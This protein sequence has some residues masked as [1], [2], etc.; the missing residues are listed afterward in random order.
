MTYTRLTSG[1]RIRQLDGVNP[2]VAVLNL[3]HLVAR[4]MN[5]VNTMGSGINCDIIS[6]MNHSNLAPFSYF[7]NRYATTNLWLA[8]GYPLSVIR[9]ILVMLPPNP[10]GWGSGRPRL[11]RHARATFESFVSNHIL[12]PGIAPLV[13]GQCIKPALCGA[14][15]AVKRDSVFQ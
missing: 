1:I 2:A 14:L 13:L 15:V 7:W 12:I 5:H 11:F 10:P 4:D 9:L 8:P 3:S 6:V